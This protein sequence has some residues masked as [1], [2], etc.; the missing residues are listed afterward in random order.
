[1]KCGTDLY[2]ILRYIKANIPFPIPIMQPHVLVAVQHGDTTSMQLLAHA[3]HHAIKGESTLLHVHLQLA[4]SL[5]TDIYAKI[6]SALI[7]SR[8]A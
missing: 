6:K 1:M 3:I 2:T 7:V 8:M 4:D 5:V